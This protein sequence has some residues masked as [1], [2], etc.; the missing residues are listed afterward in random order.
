MNG[1]SDF[2]GMTYRMRKL[3]QRNEFKSIHPVRDGL[4]GE[5][6]SY[7]RIGP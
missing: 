1:E 3:R 7:P 2:W 4:V 5:C 6:A